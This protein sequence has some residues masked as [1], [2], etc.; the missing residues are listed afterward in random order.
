LVGNRKSEI[1]QIATDIARFGKY[2]VADS[3]EP[4]QVTHVKASR[5][6][7]YDF[8]T[9]RDLADHRRTVEAGIRILL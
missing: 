2:L 1:R 5:V 4:E 9:V 7:Q 3:Q 6:V 8:P